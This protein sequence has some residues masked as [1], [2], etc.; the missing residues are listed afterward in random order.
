MIMMLKN[1]LL[2]VVC[3]VSSFSY[4]QSEMTLI[5]D[6]INDYLEGTS[7]AKPEQIKLAFHPDLNLY[8]L[9]NEG[10][11]SIWK[12]ADYIA[13]HEGQKPSHRLGEILHV[14][15]ENNAAMA[16]VEITYPQNK[17]VA[18]IDYFMLLKLEGKWTIIH[19]MYTKKD[20]SNDKK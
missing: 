15:Y 10:K 11:L 4:G 12:G 18:Y 2:L 6:T 17:E 19:K 9:D 7:L 16:K 14:D 3:F 1:I 8:S 13:G 5:E 20:T